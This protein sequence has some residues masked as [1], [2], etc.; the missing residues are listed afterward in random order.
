LILRFV[1]YVGTMLAAVFPILIAAAVGDGWTLALL[2]LGLMVVTETLV[3]QVL[4]PL[5]FGKTTGLSPVAVVVA[6]AFWTALWGPVGL[7]LSTPMTIVLLVVGRNIEALQFLEVLLGSKPVLTPDHAF[8]QR[9][10]ANDPAE[11]ADNAASYVKENTLDKY[12]AEVA[13]PGLLLAQNDKI[14]RVLTEDREVTVVSAYSELLEEI[15]PEADPAH[16]AASPIVVIAAHGA[17]NFA[18]ALS[19]SA[20]LRLKG[21]PH[22]LLPPDAVQPGR[23]PDDLA[24]GA[25]FACLCYLTAPSEARYAYTEKRIVA[26][27]AKARILGVAWRD[28]DGAHSML[29]PEHALALLPAPEASSTATESPELA[30]ATR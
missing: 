26:R 9:M 11:A 30:V 12:L 19:F 28:V 13:V 6:A 23:F 5:F 1:P 21:V 25:A 27:L 24:G 20:L 17:L 3:G 22:R 7:V 14:R 2:T 10:L 15:W 4:E 8:Y 18:A 16:D 29:A